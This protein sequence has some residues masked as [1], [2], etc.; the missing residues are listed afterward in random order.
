MP[1]ELKCEMSDVRISLNGKKYVIVDILG[2]NLMPH[3]MYKAQGFP[4]NYI[5]D[6][7][8]EGKVYSKTA[9]SARVGNSVVPLMAKILVQNQ[10]REFATA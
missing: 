3:E 2:R 6:R 7:D 9:Q 1:F 4:E 8:A 5:I 10:F